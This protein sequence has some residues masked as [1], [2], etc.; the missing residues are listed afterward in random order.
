MTFDEFK[1]KIGFK[2]DG[3]HDKGDNRTSLE[4]LE[5]VRELLQLF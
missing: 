1:E 3:E 2:D 4:I 5:E